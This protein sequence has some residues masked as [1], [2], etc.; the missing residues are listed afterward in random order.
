MTALSNGEYT[1]AMMERG[2]RTSR[3]SCSG[4]ITFSSLTRTASYLAMY[5]SKRNLADEKLERVRLAED[6]FVQ[7]LI[8]AE[9]SEDEDYESEVRYSGKTFANSRAKRDV[10]RGTSDLL[11]TFGR[12][13]SWPSRGGKLSLSK[14]YSVSAEINVSPAQ[15]I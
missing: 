8:D 11:V 14:T 6:R 4:L 12:R 2:R 1:R 7:D 15:G 10:E 5:V 3:E 9:H 13:R